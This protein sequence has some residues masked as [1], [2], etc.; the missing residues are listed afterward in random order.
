MVTFLSDLMEKGYTQGEIFAVIF[1][2]EREKK[3]RRMQGIVTETVNA[4]RLE[5]MKELLAYEKLTTWR[6]MNGFDRVV[7]GEEN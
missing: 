7:E 2:S 6:R 1:E 5:K 4:H 3:R